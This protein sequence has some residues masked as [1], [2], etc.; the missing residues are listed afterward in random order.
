MKECQRFARENMNGEVKIFTNRHGSE[1]SGS[2][3]GGLLQ[4]GEDS[5]GSQGDACGIASNFW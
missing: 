4:A 2:E 1:I 5:E 3:R